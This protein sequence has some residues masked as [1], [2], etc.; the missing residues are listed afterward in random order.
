MPRKKPK[1]GKK[2]QEENELWISPRFSLKGVYGER[3]WDNRPTGL[4]NGSRFLELADIALG[5]KKPTPR[6]AKSTSVRDTTKREP[7]KS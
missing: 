1:T 3:A 5:L 7:Y 6:K 4:P 2:A